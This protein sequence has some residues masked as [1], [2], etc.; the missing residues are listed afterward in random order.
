MKAKHYC[1]LAVLLLFATFF[2]SSCQSNFNVEPQ[3]ITLTV[4]DTYVLS[5]TVQNGTMTMKNAQMDSWE[6]SNPEVATVDDYGLVTAV[7]PGKSTVTAYYKKQKD[8]CSV[9]VI[10]G[11]KN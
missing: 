6:S 7:S 10:E 4:G 9:T 5:G 2:L 8:S 3:E 11:S 1:L